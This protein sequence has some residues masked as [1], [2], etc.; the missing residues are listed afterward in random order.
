RDRC[1]DPLSRRGGV[2]RPDR[3]HARRAFD[4]ARHARGVACANST[5]AR[6]DRRGGV[7]EGR[8]AS[9][10]RGGMNTTRIRTLIGKEL[11]ELVRDPVTLG[12]A[13]LMPLVML[14]LFGYA[15]NL[16]VEDVGLGV[17]DEDLSPASRDLI[18]RFSATP[19]F[20]LRRRF[21]STH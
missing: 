10:N 13:V 7:R 18:S 1:D 2:L 14:F 17:Y 15:V 12:L 4:R 11:R 16:D 21:E 3:P 19:Y 6:C 20:K 9:T 5:R 8:R